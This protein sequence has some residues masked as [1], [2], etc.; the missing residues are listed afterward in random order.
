[1]PKNKLHLEKRL[2]SQ[3]LLVLIAFFLMVMISNF[4]AGDIVTKHL[5]TYG[6]EAIIASAETLQ[7]Y[8]EGHQITFEDVAYVVAELYRE[9]ASLEEITQELVKWNT[10][11]HGNDARYKGFLFIYGVIDGQFVQGSNW[12]VPADYVPSTRPW[13]IG[14]YEQNGKTY[15]CDPYIDAQTGEWIMSL[16]KVLY[17]ANGKPFG[18]LA[19]DVFLSTIADYVGGMHLMNHGYGVLLD[20]NL[21]FIVHPNESV[22]GVKMDDVEKEK[23]TAMR[24]DDKLNAFNYINFS[25]VNSVMFSRKL[26][27]GWYLYVSTPYDE[28]YRD[29][30]VMFIVLSLAGMV[31]TVTL[32]GLLT[33]LHRGKARSDEANRIQTSL[34]EKANAQ[35]AAVSEAHKR[36]KGMLDTTPFGCKMWDKDL[37]IFDC[38]KAAVKLF[39]LKD[40]QEYMDRYFEMLPEHQPDGSL[41]AEKAAFYVQKAFAEGRQVF[42]WLY[43]LPDGTP[44]PSEVT[45]VRVD[46]G[47]DVAVAGYI[48]DLREYK[49]MMAEIDKQNEII[50][51]EQRK[52]EKLAHWYKSI[53]DATPLLITVTDAD[54]NWTFVN[55]AVEDFLG[56]K[57]PDMLGR[58]CSNWNAEICNTEN[59][60]IVCAKR[61][62]N[63]T[64][65]KQNGGSYQVDIEVLKDLDGDTSGYIEVV[66]DITSLQEA[67]EK[68]EAALTE[69]QNANIAKSEFL[70]NMSHEIRT[71]M[72]TVLGMTELLL[73]EPLNAR[74]RDYVHDIHVSGQS[75]LAIIND[76]L[77]M[78]KIEAG[79]LGLNPIHYDFQVF[80]D[81]LSSMLKFVSENKNIDFRFEAGPDLPEYLFGDDIRLRQ[82]LTNICGNAVKF[83]EKGYV[84]LKVIK[85]NQQLLFEIKD[86][87]TGIKKEDMGKLFNAFTQVDTHKNR[88]VVG[89][90]LGLAISK[91]FVEMMGGNITFDS[92]YGQGTTFNIKIPIVAGNEEKVRH[93]EKEHMVQPIIAPEAKILV[94][95]DNKFNLKV[96]GGLLNLSKIEPI[97]ASSGQEAIEMISQGDYDIVF[98]DHMM[99]EMDG[100]ET[101]GA[102]RRLGG[103]YENLTII[104]LTANAVFGAKEMFLANGFNGFISKPIDIHELNE[105][106]KEWLPPD[107]IEPV[108]EPGGAQADQKGTGS[109]E[110]M[111]SLE[112]VKEIDKDLGLSRVDG[113]VDMYQITLELFYNNLIGECDNMSA[114]LEGKDIN[115]FAISVHAMKSM[116]S[117]IGAMTLSEAALELELAAKKEEADY[118][119]NHYP[120][121]L[122]NLRALHKRLSA[123]FQSMETISA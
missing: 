18:V 26:F 90:G 62:L 88:K 47:Q 120:I 43:Q 110:F 111:N 123:V 121:L 89:T 63:R 117:T 71:P 87:G 1:M 33:V 38:N 119:L 48:R 57:L 49:Q 53:L 104:A 74:Q 50:S 29:V 27:N 36:A 42:E 118:C 97:T 114:L 69:A 94:V 54:M 84:R 106:L 46:Y 23:A 73:H 32:C 61:G 9:D 14:A 109:D 5:A 122:E 101:T 65:F 83:T 92:E 56:M 13:Y 11:L 79:K 98:M 55:K 8:L 96:A 66:H 34:L 40:E 107:K 105:I 91:S 51:S 99:P 86:T 58:P 39:G 2:L 17:D 77:D 75:L 3:Y 85:E 112:S 31:S 10:R 12:K 76:I 93:D 72:N 30:K 44:L 4:Y 7:T 19:F 21:R 59:C 100:V 103:K 15:Y 102:I 80:L 67:A 68:L 22:F 20:S 70:S 115:G 113:A 24:E 81:N 82:V 52:S 41:S 64:Y 108:T 116:L 60:G 25:G 45:L 16:S 28:Y 95:D 35:A 6:E 78:S 37:H